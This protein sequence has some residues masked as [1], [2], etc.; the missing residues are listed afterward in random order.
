MRSQIFALAAALAIGTATMTTHGA[1]AF[2][3]G[4]GGGWRRIPWR[5]L[6]GAH[7]G[8]MSMSHGGMAPGGGVHGLAA[9]RSGIRRARGRPWVTAPSDTVSEA[10]TLV[11]NFGYGGLYAWGGD[12]GL[13]SP[14]NDRT[15]S[16]ISASCDE[17]AG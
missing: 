12:W 4:G 7:V 15:R 16:G 2:H 5:Q 1:F 6:G 13:L 17:L 3:G 8:G 14:P 11:E 9:R 10:V